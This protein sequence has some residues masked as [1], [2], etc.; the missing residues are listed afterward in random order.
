MPFKIGA[1]KTCR[2]CLALL[3]L[4][5]AGPL[6][7]QVRVEV[8]LDQDQ[9]LPGES[10]PAT[11]RITNRSGQ[12]L[13]LGGE[14]DWLSF[15]VESRDGLV[16]AKEGEA[17]VAGAFTLEN[18]KT[19]SKRVELAPYFSI[20]EA[21]RYAVIATV[22]IP[23]WDHDVPS[24]AKTFYVIQGAKLWE[25]EFGL[26]RTEGSTNL[27]PEVRKYILQQAN[28]LKGQIRLYLRLTDQSGLKSFTVFPIGQLVSISRPE[29]QVDKFSNLHVLFATGPRAYSYNVFN[30]DG[31][32]ISRQTYDY[33]GTRPR[34]Q[35]DA[36]GKIGVLG[37]VRRV[38]RN[39]VP[40]PKEDA[41]KGEDSAR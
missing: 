40:A 32:L 33:I 23:D 11:V 28:Y 16:V 19:A 4:C 30:P 21:G 26:P 6:V 9:F 29:P 25:Q 22:R 15:E 36:E 8:T 39:D 10:L 14:E 3:L 7:A 5:S 35:L 2:F 18:S 24:L 38:T 34:L 27:A 17:P 20:I 41:E 12:T 1:M 31:D 37:G 13:H